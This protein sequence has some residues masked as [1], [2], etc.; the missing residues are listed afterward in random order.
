MKTVYYVTEGITDQIVLD[1]LVS[2]WLGEDYVPRHIQPPSSA[3]ADEL[4]LSLSQGWKGVRDW[5]AGGRSTG[6]TGRDEAIT[7][8]DCLIIHIDADVGLDPEFTN[9]PYTGPCP[10][11][12]AQCD[13]VR[14]QIT[15]MFGGVL[16][17]N[18]ALCVPAQDLEAWVLT[19]LHPAESDRHKPIECRAE[20]GALLI[21]RSPERLVNRKDK[22]IRKKVERYRD[23]AS[24]IA[25]GWSNCTKGPTPRCPEAVRFEVDAR[26]VL[27]V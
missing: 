9:P 5:C 14:A 2:A 17:A 19:A 12:K 8:A 16:P 18:V 3:Y 13:W 26:Q 4:E 11:A 7:A 25:A 20:P 15:S 10:P 27:G 22:R 21:G 1:E 24:R 23:S 6:P